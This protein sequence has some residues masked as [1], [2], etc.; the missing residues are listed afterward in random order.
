[1]LWPCRA[2][3]RCLL[4][5]DDDEFH[6]QPAGRQLVSMLG[7]DSWRAVTA[8]LTS[9]VFHTHMSSQPG[10]ADVVCA[11]DVSTPMPALTVAHTSASCSLAHS[12]KQ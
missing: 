1:M 3:E 9:L 12:A 2:A 4:V 8:V 10:A 5:L 6:G 7:L 11:Q